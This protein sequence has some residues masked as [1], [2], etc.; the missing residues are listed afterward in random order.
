LDAHKDKLRKLER[1]QL[2]GLVWG[3][4]GM[5]KKKVEDDKYGTLAI[6]FG[7]WLCKE[8]GDKDIGIAYI[9]T[10]L[11]VGNATK[12][13]QQQLRQSVMVNEHVANMIKRH[14]GT[15]AKK[16]FLTRMLQDAELQPLIQQ[17]SWNGG[18]TTP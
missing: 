1:N 9:A 4:A 8:S 17:V 3:L 15:T 11:G 18:M 10:M 5:L 14:T 13:A 2:Q 7:R 16:N 6:E 12:P